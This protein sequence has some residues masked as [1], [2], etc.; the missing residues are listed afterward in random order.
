M[1]VIDVI[2]ALDAVFPLS[3][4]DDWDNSGLIVGHPDEELTGVL[5]T[6]DI[7][8]ERVIESGRIS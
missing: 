4:Q 8:L 2:S 7:T 1:K 6:V 3:T 5:L